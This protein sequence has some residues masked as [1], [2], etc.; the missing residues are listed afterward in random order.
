MD[1]EQIGFDFV[2]GQK[3]SAVGFAISVPVGSAVASF[4]YNR[5]KADTESGIM[6]RCV[7][8]GTVWPSPEKVGSWLRYYFVLREFICHFKLGPAERTTRL[9]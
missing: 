7:E 6:C 3:V 5:R 1:I 8:I 2:K 4:M 9:Y